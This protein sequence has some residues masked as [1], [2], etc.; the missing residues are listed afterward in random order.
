MK[1]NRPSLW[2][3]CICKSHHKLNLLKH[4][5]TNI[6]NIALHIKIHLI[7]LNIYSRCLGFIQH[8]TQVR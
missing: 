2:N 6:L 7:S 4:K 3:I 5:F 1:N 8:Y